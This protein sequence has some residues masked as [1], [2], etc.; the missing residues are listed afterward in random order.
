MFIMSFNLVES[1]KE[2]LSGDM[3]NKIAGAVGESSANVQ[4]AL[5]GV[6][7]SILTGILLKAES[8]EIQETL[9]LATDASRIDI[10]HN[11]NSL[12]AWNGNSRGMDF[13]KIIFGEKTTELAA[14]VSGYAGISQESASALMSISAPAALGVLGTH[15][16]NTNMNASGLRSFLNGQKRRIL[17]SMPLGL[18]LEGILGVED[19]STVSEKFKT[20]DIPQNKPRMLARRVWLLI[21]GLIGLAAGLYYYNLQK[22]SVQSSPPV[23]DTV[24][25]A[26]DTTTTSPPSEIALAIKLPDGTVMNAKRGGV[27]DQLIDFFNDP[28][29]KPSRRYPYNFDH[30]EFNQGTAVITNESM[31]QIQNV[32][33]ILKAYPNAKIKIGGFNEKGGDSAGNRALSESRAL[34]ISAALKAAGAG[35]G[36]IISVEGFGSDFAKYPEDAPD[37]LKAKDHRIAISIRAK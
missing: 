9:N 31:A 6:V 19:L 24:K 18:F 25:A 32:A 29:S 1:V 27:E 16:L 10:P 34:S 23:T 21:V 22:P 35:K 28:E 37:S 11:L 2:V 8:G 4:Q 20:T 15:I 26:V 36:Q 3:T 14:A 17:N 5:N 30:V 7:P 12:S 13:L 33:L